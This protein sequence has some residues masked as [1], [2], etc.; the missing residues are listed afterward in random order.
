MPVQTIATQNLRV[1][2]DLD[3]ARDWRLGRATDL[4]ARRVGS[5]LLV[6]AAYDSFIFEEDGL[7]TEL[8]FSE[9]ADLGLSNAPAVTRALSGEEALEAL[10][11]RPFDLI[12]TTL[13]LGDMDI[14]TFAGAVRKTAPETPLV[15]LIPNEAELMQFGPRRAELD[16]DDIFVWYGDA[17]LFVAIIKLIEDRWNVHH[18]TQVGGVGV[19]ILVEDSVRYRSSLL[20]I[21]YGEL[22]QQTRSVMLDGLNRAQ[23]LLRL[24]AR[25]KILVAE[26]YE[27]GGELLECFRDYLFGVIT[28]VA[29]PRGGHQ[30]PQAGIDFITRA[31]ELAPDL[32]ALMQSSDESN[33]RIADQIGVAFLHKR[34]RTLLQD[35]RRFMVENFSFGEF[36]FR[37][38]D[39]REVARAGDIRE[40]CRVLRTIPLE[41]LDYHA[42][43]NHF[44]NWLRART[45]YELADRLRPVKVS[46]FEN[47]EE[48]KHYLIAAF[49]E[50]LRQNRRGVVES[51]SPERF[52]GAPGFWRIGIGSLGGKARGLVFLDAMLARHMTDFMDLGVRVYVPPCVVLCTDVFDEFLDENR[53]RSPALYTADDDWI[54]A[55]F[56]QAELPHWV[57]QRLAEYIHEVSGPVA[58]RSSS[59]LEDSQ[60]HP[61][62][63]VYDTYMI[64]N[65][66]DDEALRLRKLADTVKL[67]FASTFFAAARQ[68]L[69]AASQR[70][71]EQRMAVIL[72][73]V[74]G[75]AHEHY[76]YPSFAGVARSYNFYTFGQM[77]PEDG[78]ASVAL[79]LGQAVVEGGPALRFCPRHPHVLPQLA[80]GRAFLNQSQQTFLAV[81]LAADEDAARKPALARLDLEDA[82]RHGTL[83]AVGSVWSPENEAF[84]DG[85]YRPGARCVTFAHVLKSDLFPLAEVLRRVQELGQRGMNGPVEFEFAANLDARPREFAILQMRPFGKQSGGEA[86]EVSGS[87]ADELVCY[88]EQALGHGIIDG[89][90]DIVY[91]KPRRF[92][93]S[94]TRQIAEEIADRNQRLRSDGRRCILIGPGRWGT[95]NYWLGIPVA[96]TQISSAAVIVEAGIENFIVDPSQGSHFF[97]NLTTHGTAYMTVN[98]RLGKGFVDWNWLEAQPVE[99][100]TAFVRHVRLAE[101]VE[102]RIDGRSS[103][104]VICKRAAAAGPS[105]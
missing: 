85:I 45:E 60:Y 61:F 1:P 42:R 105:A 75:S 86:V 13:R 27:E 43:R 37:T 14:F 70:V 39:R 3:A 31:H 72:Q 62:A 26:T 25:P 24:R 64:R 47:L 73:P 12:I 48:L 92:D 97:H 69:E 94:C 66:D 88:S 56:H 34:S 15:L 57:T 104:G 79:G 96:W 53:L 54:R 35:V 5:I 103:R 98:P 7:L 33:R 99:H 28:D 36:V 81:D 91:V 21:M 51:F 41:S 71:D 40:M 9:Y 89:I 76:H 4:M 44:S 17:R 90:V 29:F 77:R 6:A 20:P 74:V 65:N 95:S 59:L 30:D 87:S 101:P 22:V 11:V 19:L 102:A 50:A 2:D 83:H 84:Y 18:D 49:D 52:D 55:A 10:R 38:P 63:G 67:V 100:E 8:I 78:V 32:P 46:E 23:R 16:V 93:A 80:V 68:Y 82:E 58:V